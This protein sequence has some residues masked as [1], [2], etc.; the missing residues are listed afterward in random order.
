MNDEKWIEEFYSD[1]EAGLDNY[2][3]PADYMERAKRI[4]NGKRKPM[5]ETKEGRKSYE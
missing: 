2:T 4:L 3:R 5:L 1:L